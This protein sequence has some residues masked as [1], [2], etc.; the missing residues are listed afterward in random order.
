MSDVRHCRTV[1]LERGGTNEVSPK[2]GCPA[3]FLEAVSGLK[4]RKGNSPEPG[5][6]LSGDRYWS[7]AKQRPQA[8]TCRGEDPR[9]GAAHTQRE[10]GR[11]RALH[12]G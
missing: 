12:K 8:R 10:T 6:S 4:P 5:V 2:V 1:V 9:G 7:S 11:L 3:G